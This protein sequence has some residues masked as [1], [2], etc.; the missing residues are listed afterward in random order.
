MKCRFFG[1]DPW[2]SASTALIRP[3]TPAAASAWPKLLFTEVRAQDPAVPYTADTLAYSIPS[4]T[5]VPV[6]CAS[7]MPTVVG[8]TPAPASADRNTAI[9]ASLEGVRMLRVRPSWLEAVPRI[10][11]STR[12][13]SRS[14]S[15]RRLSTTMPQASARTKPSAAM[16]N[17][18][19][20]PVGDS[21]P[22]PEADE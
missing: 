22:C 17:E 1:M 2:C 9:W 12:S 18:W 20:R 3:S 13:P 6:P 14:A 19:Q 4:P 21:M 15:S 16:S 11:A 7:T 5:G 10:T 8:S